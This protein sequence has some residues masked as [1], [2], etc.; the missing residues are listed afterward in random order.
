[1][2]TIRLLDAND[3]YN[4]YLQ[5]LEQL[6][7]V[8]DITFDRLCDQLKQIELDRN[9]NIYVMFSQTGELVATGSLIVERKIIHNLS[10]VGHIEDIVVDKKHRKKGYGKMMIDY[11]VGIAKDNNCYKVILNCK[12]SNSL[13][14][15]KCGFSKTEIEMTFRL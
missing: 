4:N 1:M 5:L 2:L 14:Y 7:D 12:E 6:T 13:F 9:I 15:E 3:Y 10:S 11:L 8:G